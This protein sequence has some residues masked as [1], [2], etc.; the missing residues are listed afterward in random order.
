MSRCF[1]VDRFSMPI[2]GQGLV[3]IK[4]KIKVKINA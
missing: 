4:V 1:A 2:L 3:Q